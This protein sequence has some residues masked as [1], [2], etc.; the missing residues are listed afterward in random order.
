MVSGLKVRLDDGSEVGPLEMAM[1]RSWYEQGLIN[2]ESAVQ[3]S[4]SKSWMKLSQAIDLRA[5]G[6]LTSAPKKAVRKASQ[7]A[8]GT[9]AKAEDREIPSGRAPLAEHWATSLGGLLLLVGAGAA[10]FF[11]LHPQDAVPPLDRAPWWPV[12]LGLLACALALLPGWELSRKLARVA[13]LVA[14]VLAFPLLGILFAQGVRGAALVAVLGIVVLFFGLFA[15]LSEP[16]PHWAKGALGLSAVLGGGI[17][18]GY[19]VYAAETDAQKQI[20][21]ATT[22][23]RRFSDPSLGVNLELP[24]GWTLLKKDTA[25]VTTPADARV[26][27]AHPRQ[28]AFGYLT[29]ASSPEG[30]TSLDGWLDR[31][32]AE[33]RKIEAGLKEESRTEVAVGT[34]TGR[35][36]SA[37]WSA[38]GSTYRE[39]ATAWRDGW[40]YYALVAWA[41]EAAGAADLDALANGV[42]TSGTLAANLQ[43][44][45][46]KVTLEVPALT[47]AAAELL[48]ARSEAKVLEPDQAFRRSFEA[49]ANALPGWKAGEAQEMGRLIA[50]CYATLTPRDRTRLAAYVDKVQKHQLTTP[51][52]DREMAQLMK[53]AVLRLPEPKRTRL[54]VLYEKAVE[55]AASPS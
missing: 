25:V 5:W 33:R 50:S 16:A 28:Q 11:H 14:A 12:A 36:A 23:E 49:V 24:E 46:Q 39:T 9:R 40:V 1:V 29:T 27:F 13:A 7:A 26:A 2:P 30:V 54:Q 4:G 32:M 44:A 6:N 52:E 21:E 42:S 45:V 53:A 38:S 51:A 8:P 15:F 10:V 48:M 55:D 22:T 3:R 31:V 19:F 35:K 34:L 17:L 20:R 37:T 18:A 47:P 43:K 41:P